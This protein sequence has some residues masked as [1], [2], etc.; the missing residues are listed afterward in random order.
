MKLRALLITISLAV[1]A[2]HTVLLS[3]TATAPLPASQPSTTLFFRGW[4]HYSDG[5]DPGNYD[6][7][8]YYK[9]HAASTTALVS[10]T[11]SHS[12]NNSLQVTDAATATGA[13]GVLVLQIN[14]TQPA[15]PP[16][17]AVSLWF[18]RTSTGSYTTG[19]AGIGLLGNYSLD[20]A[21]EYISAFRITGDNALGACSADSICFY[22]PGAGDYAVVE[23]LVYDTWYR[24]MWEVYYD[25][26]AIYLDMYLNA[27]LVLNHTPL[28][29]SGLGL[30][31]LLHAFLIETDGISGRT[32]SVFYDDFAVMGNKDVVPADAYIAPIAVMVPSFNR[33]DFNDLRYVQYADNIT[34]YSYDGPDEWTSVVDNLVELGDPGYE[35]DEGTGEGTVFYEDG[36][37]YYYY[38]MR[39][40]TFPIDAVG[41]ATSNDGENFTKY[42]GNGN[43]PTTRG[44]VFRN[45]PVAGRWDSYHV[46]NPSFVTY[47]GD[48]YWMIYT[49]TDV[50]AG[51]G[52]RYR[53]GLAFS[54]NLTWWYRYPSNSSNEPFVS[55][56]WGDDCYADAY[57]EST[58][59]DEDANL[60][61][62]LLHCKQTETGATRTLHQATSP[63]LITWTIDTTSDGRIFPETVTHSGSTWERD[64]L[65]YMFYKR[66]LST[67]PVQDHR[68]GLAFSFDGE[69]WQNTKYVFLQPADI[70]DIYVNTTNHGRTQ[71]Y[72]QFLNDTMR[73]WISGF[74]TDGNTYTSIIERPI[75]RFR[76]I[77]L[78]PNATTG[79]F[80]T[81]RLATIA[82][83]I[84]V[85]VQNTATSNVTVEILN[86]AG[87]I[88][89]GSS[90]PI[91]TSGATINVTWRGETIIQ[92]PSQF[93]VRIR[94]SEG[95]E[96]FDIGFST[97][98]F[99]EAAQSWLIEYGPAWLSFLI[100]AG[101][102]LLVFTSFYSGIKHRRKKKGKIWAFMPKKFRRR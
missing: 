99:S 12:G 38:T 77:Q 33:I 70:P 95:A 19:Y 79:Y 6:E 98:S 23:S 25:A 8:V 51:A 26:G 88:V 65:W 93:T 11:T 2:L 28:M 56:P 40:G 82:R 72:Q 75:N 78:L 39:D 46:F 29:N 91:T 80:T 85:N 97:A 49:G 36:V 13:N 1:A 50:A 18:N 7:N 15:I 52:E 42:T 84:T 43:G 20:N 81:H 4:E 22:D 66:A 54:Y 37:Y 86:A 59:W 44:V 31:G 24:A 90:D 35:D 21:Q 41:L 87:E 74:S 96:L 94:L 5:T 71:A 53:S 64:G 55:A 63:D 101:I 73:L 69:T 62:S 48:R 76:Y 68:T 14:M 58:V 100:S 10:E 60:Y 3:P 30:Q 27:S 17:Y 102:M 9:R 45:N 83:G 57:W 92:V 67:P 16:Q 32:S 47:R 61:R 89:Y 34:Q